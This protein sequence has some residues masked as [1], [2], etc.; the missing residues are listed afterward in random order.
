MHDCV[1]IGGGPGGLSAALMLG[2]AR[3]LTIVLDAG[4]PRNAASHALHGFVTRDGIGP[5]EFLDLARRELER[6]ETVSLRSACAEAV[7]IIDGG[8][9]VQVAGGPAMEARTLVLATGVRD[10]LPDIDGLK[11]HQ[12]ASLSLLRWMG[13]P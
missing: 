1:I 10:K 7:E 8:F 9:R 11:R 2:R 13:A 6:Y 4:E 5:A 3:R 12:R